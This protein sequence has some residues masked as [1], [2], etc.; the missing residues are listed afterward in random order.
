MEKEILLGYAAVDSGQLLIT[1]PCYIDDEWKETSDEELAETLKRTYKHKK[2][3]KKYTHWKDFNSFED[4]IG[5]K[6]INQLI[7]EKI[8]VKTKTK[9]KDKHKYSY[10]GCCD[11]TIKSKQSAG[12]LNFKLGHKGVGVVTSTGWGDGV[13][14]VYGILGEEDRIMKIIIK[15]N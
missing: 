3:G 7:K 4:K 2:T 6:T 5:K 1:D 14:P 12:Q 11:A 13:Y 15:F 10:A 9:R 8:L